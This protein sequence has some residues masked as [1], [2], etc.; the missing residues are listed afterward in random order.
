MRLPRLV[1]QWNTPARRWRLLALGAAVGLGN[2]CAKLNG[3]DA[4]EAVDCVH[5]P[6][7]D[8]A[9]DTADESLDADDGSADVAD[10]GPDARETGD[11]GDGGADTTDVRDADAPLDVPM[12][13]DA[14]DTLV[15]TTPSCPDA[16][17][18]TT[19]EETDAGS[20][21]PTGPGPTMVSVGTYCID[22]TEVTNAQYAAFLV[23]KPDVCKQSPQCAWNTSF[24]PS[25]AW[26]APTGK[27][28]NPVVYVDWCDAAAYCAF[29]GK[30]LCGRIAGG[31]NPTGSYTD[32]AS[33]QW[34]RACSKAGA[35][36]YPY[37]STYSSTACN[38]GD[39]AV[40][41]TVAV[42]TKSG[43]E[44]AYTGLFDLSGNAWEWEDSCDVSASGATD[45]CRL[46]GGSWS[47]TAPSLRCDVNFLGGFTARSKVYNN[48]GFRCC[49]R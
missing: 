18:D 10:S 13:T 33:S 23:A 43:C 45:P 20:L 7:T 37:G 39:L 24:T 1:S 4:L 47:D 31:S 34:Y 21:C 28:S 25:S 17:F 40:G 12:E 9:S 35:Q 19:T 27:E 15:D 36:T 32:A 6:C 46:R 42:G 29:A 2:A 30:R 11:G 38:G 5:A 14:T 26:P 41:T 44:G 22:S 3:L 8:A 49:S 16:A 48:V